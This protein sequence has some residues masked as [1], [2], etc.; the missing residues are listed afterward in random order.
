MC[1]DSHEEVNKGFK[2]LS[3]CKKT[4]GKFK[5]NEFY[6]SFYSKQIEASFHS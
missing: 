5:T 4:A 6:K 3:L 1:T 2:I